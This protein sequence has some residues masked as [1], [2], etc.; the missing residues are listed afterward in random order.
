M[1]KKYNEVPAKDNMKVEANVE[2]TQVV[3]D[4]KPKLQKVVS[5]QPTKVKRNLFSRLVTGVLGPDGLPGLGNY[6]AEEIVIPAVKNLIYDA[7]ESTARKAMFGRGGGPARG[8]YGRSYGNA[9]RQATNYN[10]RYATSTRREAEDDRKVVR[11]SSRFGVDEYIIEDRQSA[12]EVLTTLTEQADRYN[13]SSVADYYE[14]IGVDAKHTDHNY[15]WS[16]DTIHDATIQP[17]RGGYIIKF[18]PV[19]VI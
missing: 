2:E 17:I 13:V 3:S 4:N 10:N 14:L 8:G 19:E 15:G 12:V 16:I 18:P 1:T 6:V 5:A 9:P 11:P 7:I